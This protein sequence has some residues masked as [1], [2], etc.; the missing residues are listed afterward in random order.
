MPLFA[1]NIFYAFF[2]VVFCKFL[3]NKLKH[4]GDTNT[5]YLVAVFDEVISELFDGHVCITCGLLFTVDTDQDTLAGLDCSCTTLTLLKVDGAVISL[6]D[7]V[8]FT[9]NVW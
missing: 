2:F 9:F 3:F 5:E 1:T 6:D 7:N 4:V 8:F